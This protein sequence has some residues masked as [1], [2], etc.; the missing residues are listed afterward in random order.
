MLDEGFDAHVH[1]AQAGAD[2]LFKGFAAAQVND[3]NRGPGG[4]RKAHQVMDPLRLDVWRAA[5]VV[6][7]R[8]GFPI[9]EQRLLEF[10]NEGFIFAMRRRHHAE[11]AREPEGGEEFRVVDP[12]RAFVGEEDFERLDTLGNDL[13]HLPL[14]AAVKPRDPHMEGVVAAGFSVGQG[15]PSGEAIGGFFRPRRATH[16]EDG[17]GPA[18][19][20]GL[21]ARGVGVLGGCPHKRQVDVRVRVD[22]SREHEFSRRIHDLGTGRGREILP[23]ARDRL[24]FAP[25][26]RHKPG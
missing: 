12:E 19:N 6:P 14:R 15:F 23:D 21:R 2:R 5:F 1:A 7:F 20:R 8:A 16:V 17:R 4:F 13:T 9:R 26:V 18:D 3:V 11:F 10:G 25:D 22:E 24:P